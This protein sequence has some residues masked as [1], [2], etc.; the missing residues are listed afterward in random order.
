MLQD[1]EQPVLMEAG[2]KGPRKMCPEKQGANRLLDMFNCTEKS[3]IVLAKTL[4]MN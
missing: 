1:N 3:F 2:E 4:W